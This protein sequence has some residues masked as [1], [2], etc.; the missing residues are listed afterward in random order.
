M[1][2]AELEYFP[3][4]ELM[5]VAATERVPLKRWASAEEIADAILYL[6][7]STYATGSVWSI[8]GGT[9]AI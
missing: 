5:R 6:G 7:S 9:T 3:H 8:D 1:L 2:E 4:P